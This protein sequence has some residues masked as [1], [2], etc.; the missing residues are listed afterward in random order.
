M[1]LK[2]YIELKD[3]RIF[4]HHGVIPQERVVGAVFI[5]SVSIGYDLSKAM[6]TDDLGDTLN[7]ASVYELIKKEMDIPSN[8][9]EHV[10]RRIERALK[11]TFPDIC[12]LHLTLSKE[13]PPMGAN[14]NEVGVR[15]DITY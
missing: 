14:C 15:L 1:E 7:Y 9:L 6:I 8:L 12:S 3:I 5:I 11:S 2:S 4:S 13:N 10:A